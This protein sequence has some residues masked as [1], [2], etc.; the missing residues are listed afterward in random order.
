ME[1]MPWSVYIIMPL[2]S[3]PAPAGGGYTDM[4]RPD[5]QDCER[6]FSQRPRWG[7]SCPDGECASSNDAWM[8]MKYGDYYL[9]PYGMVRYGR[10]VSIGV[11]AARRDGGQPT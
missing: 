2:I 10:F 6:L 3:G 5:A 8:P 9:V 7:G 4:N 1:I 11:R